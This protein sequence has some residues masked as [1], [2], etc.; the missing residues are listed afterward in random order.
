MAGVSVWTGVVVPRVADVRR[1]VYPYTYTALGASVKISSVFLELYIKVKHALM[2][3]K[4]DNCD[5]SLN[6]EM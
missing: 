6:D 2:L 4:S 1:V 5:R 3:L